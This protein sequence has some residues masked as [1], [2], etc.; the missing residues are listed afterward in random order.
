MYCSKKLARLRVDEF[1]LFARIIT[2]CQWKGP[3]WRLTFVSSPEIVHIFQ[4]LL[5]DRSTSR[6]RRAARPNIVITTPF[7]RG[8][9]GNKLVQVYNSLLDAKHKI[10]SAGK[11]GLG[12]GG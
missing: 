7:S 1:V 12:P 3:Q 5:S 8:P 9:G 6:K 11:A 10:G 4:I 2:A